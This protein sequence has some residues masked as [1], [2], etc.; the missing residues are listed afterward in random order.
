MPVTQRRSRKQIRHSIGLL[1]GAVRQESG[2][3]ESS[4]TETA[5]NAV[6]LIDNALA[7]G[8]ENEHRGRWIYATDSAGL[9]QMRR[10]IASSI[11][12]RSITVSRAVDSVVGS[13]HVYEIWDA[14]MPPE[15]VHDFIGQAISGVTRKGSVATTDESFH[16]GGNINAYSLSSAWA[17][18]RDLSWRSGFHG[19]QVASLDS[20]MTPVSG[21][22]TVSLDAKDFREGGGAARVEVSAAAAAGESL[23]ES[24]F[25]STDAR[26]FDRIEFWRKSSVTQTSS[27][28]VIELH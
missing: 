4:P 1:L 7:F 20:P 8:T 3:I 22:V 6:K 28:L 11:D 2:Q 24:S 13:S 10:V 26:G 17:G 21:N 5:P 12:D 23:A 18:V 14:D 9:T 19:V 27:N 25:H 16:T 15:S